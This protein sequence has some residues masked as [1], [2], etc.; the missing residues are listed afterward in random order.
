MMNGNGRKIVLYIILSAIVVLLFLFCG[1]TVVADE[2]IM[3]N[4][5]TH[6]VTT[7]TT[8]DFSTATLIGLPPSVTNF[9]AGSLFPL[10]QTTVTNPTTTP[11]LTFAPLGVAP[12]QFYGNN[13]AASAMPTFAQIDFANLSGTASNFQ[14]AAMPANTI[15]GRQTTSGLVTD[16]TAAQTKTLLNLDSVEN[17][18]LSTWP[19]STNITTLGTVTTGVWNGTAIAPGKGGAPTGGTVGQVLTKNTATN[20][21]Y[22]WASPAG[23]GTVTSFTAG[24]LSPL[25]TTSVTN[26][27]TTPALSFALSTAGA[28]QFLGNNTASTAAPSYVQPGFTD[29]TGAAGTAQGGLPT[30]GTTGQRLVKSSATNYDTS[31]VSNIT[32]V[33]DASDAPSGAVGEY[34]V[35]NGSAIGITTGVWKTLMTFALPAGDWDVNAQVSISITSPSGN[36]TVAAGVGGTANSD[37]GGIQMNIPAATYQKFAAPYK[38]LNYGATTNIYVNAYVNTAGTIS[39]IAYLQARRAR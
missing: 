10:F 31:W 30:G 36:M 18:A 28:H 29:L 23:T 14:L 16:L 12:N 15:K 7:P 17:T 38:R 6:K 20:Y 22:T 39:G 21:D 13:T 1:R 26:S 19:G 2:P 3:L 24:N 5:K 27:T 9:G 37:P 4:T 34:L 33:T 32:G 8:I 25:F 11:M 35:S